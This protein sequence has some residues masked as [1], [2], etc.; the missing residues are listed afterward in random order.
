ME[1]LKYCGNAESSRKKIVQSLI[2]RHFATV[3][4]RI[5]WFSPNVQKLTG[6]MNIGNIL[7]IV[8]KS[9]LSGIC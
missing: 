7:N 4:S 9:S 3:C 1:V 6:N 8:I 2:H 5:T